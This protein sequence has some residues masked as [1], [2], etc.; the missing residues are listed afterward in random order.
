MEEKK[1][2][3]PDM[4]TRSLSI[5]SGLAW[6]EGTDGDT[7]AQDGALQA[8]SVVQEYAALMRKADEVLYRAKKDGRGRY[9]VFG[10]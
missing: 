2:L 8:E 3:F 7:A 10:E 5:S 9:M 1:I 6:Y 4:S